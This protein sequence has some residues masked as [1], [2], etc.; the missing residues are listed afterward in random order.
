MWSS[1]WGDSQ[2]GRDQSAKNV[3][4]AVEVGVI[5]ECVLVC[6]NL[7]LRH[8]GFVGIDVLGL[9]MAD[10]SDES[11]LLDLF[12]KYSLESSSP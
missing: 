7:S 9:V 1:R 6:S 10:E 3:E 5:Y 12:S 11:L 8:R 2:R 4:C